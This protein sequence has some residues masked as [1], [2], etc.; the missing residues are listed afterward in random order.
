[1]VSGH[2]SVCVYFF[3][4]VIIIIISRVL[5]F[6]PS[7]C[8]IF[9]PME[10][11][12]PT[13]KSHQQAHVDNAAH[14]PWPATTTGRRPG[15]NAPVQASTT[16]DHMDLDVCDD[17]PKLMTSLIKTLERHMLFSVL[18]FLCWNYFCHPS[19]GPGQHYVFGLSVCLHMCM[20][21]RLQAFSEWFAIE[22]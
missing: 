10:Q 6:Q 21:T 18:V 4:S 5:Q 3:L 13:L 1:V 11:T 7:D 12:Q 22:F 2:W 17:M 8:I 15:E 14:S 20:T 9:R 16:W 19:C